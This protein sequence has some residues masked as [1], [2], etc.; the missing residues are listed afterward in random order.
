MGVCMY[1]ALSR[2]CRTCENIECAT[3]GVAGIGM[4]SSVYICPQRNLKPC[5]NIMGQ[6]SELRV[7]IF[8]RL[9]ISRTHDS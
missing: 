9:L 2:G 7:K 1:V 6:L 3:R 5:L 8:F 4:G